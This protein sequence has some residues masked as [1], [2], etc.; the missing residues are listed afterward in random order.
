MKLYEI[1]EQIEKVISEAIDIETGEIVEE[2]AL[3]KLDDLN[4]ERQVKC[5]DIACV[6]KSLNYQEKALAEEIGK[7]QKRKKSAQNQ[8]EWLKRYLK[9]SVKPGEKMR[10]ARA[11]IS[12]RKSSQVLVSIEPAKLPKQFQDIKITPN[13][14]FLKAYLKEG[15]IVDGVSIQENQNI[16]IK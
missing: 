12:W 4:I 14:T 11:A 13:K 3:E 9:I 15:N 8:I 5:I 6:V 10:D 7:L 16:S 2:S 1:T